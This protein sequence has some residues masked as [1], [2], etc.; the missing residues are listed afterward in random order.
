VQTCLGAIEGH[1]LLESVCTNFKAHDARRGRNNFKGKARTEG[2]N[3]VW[4]RATSTLGP[5]RAPSTQ[6]LAS[7]G[8]SNLSLQ[9]Y[10]Q[11]LHAGLLALLSLF[12]FFLPVS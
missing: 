9:L 11:Q 4:A 5:L 10:Q 7:P 1:L 6:L 8:A 3:G 2:S 12:F